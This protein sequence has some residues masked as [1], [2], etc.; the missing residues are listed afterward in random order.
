MAV[1]Y[2]G[3]RPPCYP[4]SN[5]GNFNIAPPYYPHF[6]GKRPTLTDLVAREVTVAKKWEVHPDYLGNVDEDG[7]GGEDTYWCQHHVHSHR[8]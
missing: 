5:W 2:F 4:K 1:V 6:T 3:K 7:E 8:T